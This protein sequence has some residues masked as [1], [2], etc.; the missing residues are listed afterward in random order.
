[1]GGGWSAEHG[2]TLEARAVRA[3]AALCVKWH[4]RKSIVDP[5]AAVA[6]AFHR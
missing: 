1:L 6:T 4:D 3:S 5:I 2:A